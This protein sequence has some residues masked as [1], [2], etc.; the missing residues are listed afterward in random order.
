MVEP[1]WLWFVG[2][3]LLCLTLLLGIVIKLVEIRRL[4]KNRRRFID[5]LTNHYERIEDRSKTDRSG[6]REG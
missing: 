3:G 2:L 1:D 5:Q 4:L 6:S